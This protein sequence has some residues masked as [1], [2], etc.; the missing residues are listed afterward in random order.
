MGVGGLNRP[1]KGE[2][3]CKGLSSHLVKQAP[4][5][6][7][8]GLENL[9][10]TLTLNSTA[11]A[12]DGVFRGGGATVTSWPATVGNNM[13]I[14]NVGTDVTVGQAVPWGC[15]KDAGVL[16]NNADYYEGHTDDGD[17]GTNDF[18]IEYVIKTSS[19]FVADQ[20]IVA[21]GK[22]TGNT[23][24]AW[25][26][27]INSSGKPSTTIWDGASAVVAVATS[28]LSTSTN[29][30]VMIFGDRSGNMHYLINGTADGTRS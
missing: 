24:G 7:M 30:H 26:S 22:S 2:G 10:S 3:L 25:F 6:E 21:H 8:C 4:F 17:F 28:A 14:I 16:F 23:N 18:V 27:V 11:Q 29:Y 20:T 5:H 9:N 15:S 12:A 19:S 1:S 13:S